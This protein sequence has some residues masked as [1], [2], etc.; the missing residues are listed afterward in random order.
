MDLFR[1]IEI[2]KTI[3]EKTLK[4]NTGKPIFLAKRLGISRSQLY[5]LIDFLKDYGAPIKYDRALETFYYEKPFRIKIDFKLE[6]LTINELKEIN[7]GILF[8]KFFP[9]HFLGRNTFNLAV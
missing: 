6:D 5:K 8:F 4:K 1:Q 3:N 7:G 2:I 9:V